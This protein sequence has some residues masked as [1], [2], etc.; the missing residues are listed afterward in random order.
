MKTI[1]LNNGVEMPILGFGVYQVEPKDTESIVSDALEVGYK[2]IDTASAYMNEEGV[3]NAIK[4]SGIAREDLFITT[5]LWIKDTGYEKTKKAFDISL[6]KL[7]LDYLDLWLIH[8]PFGD[9]FGAWRAMEELY[10]EGRIRAIGVSNFQQDRVLDLI[11]NSEIVPAINQV[12][13]HVFNQ[14]VENQ[15][16][17]KQN[18]VQIESWGSFA[19]GRNDMFNNPTLKSIG[20][21]YGKSIAQVILRWL[22]ERDVVVIPKSVRRDRMAENLNIFDFE[23]SP[24]DMNIIQSLDQDKSLFFDHRD[25]EFVKMINQWKF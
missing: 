16:F 25:L 15:K 24:D 3:G 14:Q 1:K 9:I 4:N 23:L 17:L 19:E 22:T 2:A 5:K 11:L 13:T 12:E 8:Q 20:D 10:K 21:K 6:K 7:Q 18:G